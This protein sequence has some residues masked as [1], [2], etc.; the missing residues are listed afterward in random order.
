[1]SSFNP[2]KDKIMVYMD[3]GFQ[4]PKWA[5]WYLFSMIFSKQLSLLADLN[6]TNMSN[7]EMLTTQNFWMHFPQG[8]LY[9]LL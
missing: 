9:K 2:F 3:S 6:T 8:V 7:D 1:M 4:Y 5:S